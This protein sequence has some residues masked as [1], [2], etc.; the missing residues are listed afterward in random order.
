M[1]TFLYQ[2]WIEYKLYFRSPGSLLWSFLFP[3]ITISALG[4]HFG[5]EKP[6]TVAIGWVDEDQSPQSRQL[7]EF[8]Y[9][10]A[11]QFKIEE[12][13]KSTFEKKIKNH[14]KAA[15]IYVP[16]GYQNAHQPIE[17]VYNPYQVQSI[18]YISLLLDK[19]IA[20][21][22]LAQNRIPSLTTYQKKALTVNPK[23][24]YLDFLVPGVLSLQIMSYCLWSIGFVMLS[25]REKGNLKRI[26][27]TP[28]R[29]STYILSQIVHRYS[30]VIL[31]S[32]FIVA[33]AYWA[34]NVKVRGDVFSLWLALSI[35]MFTFMAIGF[36]IASVVPNI[37]LCIGINNLLF[38]LMLA[39]SG[40]FFSTDNLPSFLQ[41]ISKVL[42]LTH[43]AD[44]VRGI[45][46]EGSSLLDFK[47]GLLVLLLYFGVAFAGSVHFFRW[48]S[49]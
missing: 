2:L 32:L 1:K 14:Q 20:E 19:I 23:K 7:K 15:Y 45:Y 39:L 8:L 29:K 17:L 9:Q 38:L 49:K 12:G 46:V 16:K 10:H 41:G 30:I 18:L 25:Y 40:I 11:Q 28:V 13:Q 44:M 43:L 21:F 22:N 3:A 26:A 47:Y 34:F 33:F 24:S 27:V 37:E 48:T 42:P 31:Q 36:F 35:G 5:N 4:V 6:I